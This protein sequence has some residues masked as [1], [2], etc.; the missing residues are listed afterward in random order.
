MQFSEIIGQEH[1]KS[2]LI[3]SAKNG[4]IP[5]AQLFVGASGS[6]VLP[7]AIAYSNYILC[8]GFGNNTAENEDSCS[9][10]VKKLMH[11]DLHFVYPVANNADVKS[12]AVSSHFSESWRKFV[13]EKPYGSLFEWYQKIGIENKQ[14]K[15]GVDEAAD[16]VKKLSLKAYEGGYKIMI[17]WMAEKMNNDCSNKI[18]KLVEEPPEK[19]LLLL[20]AE[21]E[22]QLITTIRSR[23][24]ALHFPGLSEE[25][26]AESLIKNEGV[27]DHEALQIAHRASGD[28][29]KAMHLLKND[30]EDAFF[31]K[32]FIVW[33][34]S[35]FLAKGNKKAIQ[36]LLA[37]SDEIAKTGRETQKKFLLFCIEFFRNTLLINYNTQNLAY[38][39]PVDPNFSLKKFAPFVHENNI[40]EIIDLVEEAI[41]H[42]E[43]NGNGK[44]IFSDLAIKLSRLIH[45]KTTKT[46]L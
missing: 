32:W 43:R 10:K 41:Y 17:I 21:N 20:I 2:H 42:V 37:W 38:Y 30:G 45:K 27:L 3:T 19:T 35:A 26:I 4:R 6:G 31:E 34:R 16:I 25:N 1:I 9:I 7:M 36:D 12:H 28:Y 29:N 24:Q 5:H 8:N 22:E 11:P 13:F 18:L 44:I 15:I 40:L 14:G 23:C 46:T 33:V 39:K